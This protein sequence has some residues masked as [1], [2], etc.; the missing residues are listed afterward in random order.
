[1]VIIGILFFL[2][3]F[4]TW[5]NGALIPF[6]Q[7]VCELSETQ[8]LFISFSF[9]I[10]YVVM[11]LPMSWVLDRTGY[12]NG[13]ALGL[14]TMAV[15]CLLFIPAAFSQVFFIFLLAQFIVGAGLTILQTASN[16]YIVKI[17]PSETAAVRISIMGLLN[18]FAGILAPMV[19]TAL[20]L[21]DFSN[22]NI[23]YMNTLNVTQKQEKIEALSNAL[24]LPYIYMAGVLLV[25]AILL[26]LSSL[27]E[28][29]L[30]TT[31][32]PQQGKSVFSHPHLILGVVAI[33]LY[34]GVEV[35]AGDT[36]GIYGSQLGINNAI[37]LTSYTMAFMVTGYL[38]GLA[39]IPRFI[40]QSSALACSAILGLLLSVL[41]VFADNQATTISSVM[42][43]WMGI[44]LLPDSVALIA[45]LG[46]ANALVWPAVWPLALEGLSTLTARASA[47]LIMGI[48]GGA[49]L[50]VI[51]GFFSETFSSQ[52]AYWIMLPCYGFILFYA[53]HGHKMREWWGEK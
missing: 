10:A 2:F 42:W 19:F 45:I 40:D 50:P 13:M 52:S 27:P 8:A 17:G 9:Y 11:A 3:G 41:I 20:V 15:G 47:L 29:K 37:S 44:P 22:V 1:M 24:V 38:L 6:L 7:I 33:F 28:L 30:E 23:Q 43:G 16:P 31:N 39:L 51:Y 35:I 4:V 25:L 18:K 14:A 48:S 36:I 46:F 53:L 26:K 12:K 21:S 34:V 32:S 5:L 49:I